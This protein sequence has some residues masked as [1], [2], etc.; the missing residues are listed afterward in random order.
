MSCPTVVYDDAVTSTDLDEWRDEF[1][2]VMGR[3]RSL[4]YRAESKKHAEQ[5]VRG[6]LAP[7][8]RKNGWTI[9]E[10]VGEPEPKALQRLLNLS[11]WDVDALLALNREYAMENLATP[12]AILVA[13]P[14]GFAKKGRM[15]VGVQRQYSGTLGRI[16]NCQIATFLAYVTPGRDRVLIDRRLYLPDKSWM[17]HP[18]RCAQAGVPPEVTFQTRPRQVQQMIEDARA[19]GLPFTWF[20]ADEEFGQ[21]PGLCAYLERERLPYVMAIPKNTTFGDSTGVEKKIEIYA[22]K[23][24]RNSWQRR[25][26]GIGAKG[27]RVYDWALTGSAGPDLHYLI[28]RSITDGELAFYR[29]Y[30]PNR[31]GLGEL[32]NVAGARWP[33]EECFGS[34]KNETGLDNYQVRTWTAWHR[35]IT[36]AMLA[37]T[38]LAVTAHKAKKGEA[39]LSQPNPTRRHPSADA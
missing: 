15:S 25:A 37:H 10:Y 28:R 8:A 5:Y 4:F 34:S 1:D 21:N 11:P 30:N 20:A 26:C 29:C 9:S 2:A 18:D 22:Q 35:H 12:G 32:V 27:H 17:A 24:P 31:A 19:A 23:L 33:I 38:F 13:D 39:A 3:M 36:F 6:L 14:T 7:L 16:D